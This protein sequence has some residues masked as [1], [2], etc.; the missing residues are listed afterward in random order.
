MLAAERIGAGRL[1]G[2][3]VVLDIGTSR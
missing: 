3:V 2:A 1:S